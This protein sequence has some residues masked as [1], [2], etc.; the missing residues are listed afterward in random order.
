MDKLEL[1]KKL[2][3]VK[4][5]IIDLHSASLTSKAKTMDIELKLQRK[6]NFYNGMLRSA[7]W[8]KIYLEKQL[9]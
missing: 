5:N 4:Q 2:L 9:T 1:R 6:Y 3:E 8:K 7:K